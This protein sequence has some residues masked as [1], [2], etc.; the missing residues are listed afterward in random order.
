MTDLDWKPVGTALLGTWPAQVAA[1]G[2]EGIAAYISELGARGVDPERALAAI[3]CYD[4]DADFPPSAAKLAQVAR[5][6][7]GAPTGLE[8]VAIL[9]ATGGVMHARAEYPEGGWRGANARDAADDQA[10]L[11][12]ATQHHPRI[13]AFIE[14]VGLEAL[15]NRDPRG[16]QFGEANRNWLVREWDAFTEKANE[17]GVAALLAGAHIDPL[18]AL[19]RGQER[20]RPALAPGSE[21]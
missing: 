21:S 19:R 15:K 2:P 12:A 9:W 13:V 1:W 20:Q 6:D 14:T 17:R 8:V 11:Y 10:R 18:A 16:E 7:P 4:P 3:R 5:R